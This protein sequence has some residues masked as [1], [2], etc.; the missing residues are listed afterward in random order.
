MR[1]LVITSLFAALICSCSGVQAATI[2]IAAGPGLAANAAAL[3]AFN[4]AAAQWEQ[5]LADPI[6]VRIEADLF[7]L[8]AGI[9]NETF[10]EVNILSY[11]NDIRPAL[12]ADAEGQP[13]N[14]IVSFLPTGDNDDPLEVFLPDGFTPTLTSQ[15]PTAN[16]KALGLMPSYPDDNPDDADGFI[17]I[18]TFSGGVDFDFD[19]SDGVLGMHVDFETFAAREIGHVLGFYS[20]ADF[21]DMVLGGEIPPSDGDTIA[22]T[23]MDLFRF[24]DDND[25]SP[26]TNGE[27]FNSFA[28]S[29]HASNF[30]VFGD[31][32]NSWRLSAGGF[33]GDG[34]RSDTWKDN[35]LVNPDDPPIG[36]MD[37]NIPLSF[38]DQSGVTEISAAD[39]RVLDLIG[40]DLVEVPEPTSALLAMMAACCL[41]LRPWRARRK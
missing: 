3:G 34:N 14:E 23:T 35:A 11:Q 26:P 7:D 29:L 2:N 32:T 1:T 13:N 33:D 18:N 41:A 24:R 39:L 31:G 4:R 9:V 8:G 19:N 17:D 20:D 16:L 6:V 12:I 10:V 38:Q 21:I 28:R 36:I 25:G 40:Y 22:L 37:P 15:V 27:E 30:E 5:H